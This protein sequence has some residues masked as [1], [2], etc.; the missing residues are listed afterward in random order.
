MTIAVVINISGRMGL[1]LCAQLN[2][3]LGLGGRG[4]LR[5][6]WRAILTNLL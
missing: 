1:S 5:L 3:I 6:G 4:M 2:R